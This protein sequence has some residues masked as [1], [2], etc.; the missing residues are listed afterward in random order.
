[1]DTI[2]SKFKRLHEIYCLEKSTINTHTVRKALIKHP[3]GRLLNFLPFKEGAYSSGRLFNLLKNDAP[4]LCIVF[5]SDHKKQISSCRKFERKET[6]ETGLLS[7]NYK[8]N[9][10]LC[11]LQ[12]L[13]INFEV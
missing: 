7:E 3:G 2:T 1:M 13:K 8:K 9:T 11:Y 5:I 12:E 6:L 4:S 10:L